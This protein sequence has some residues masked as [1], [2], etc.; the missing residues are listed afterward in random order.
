[1]R[2]GVLAFDESD[3]R[4]IIATVDDE[5]IPLDRQL[6]GS[7]LALHRNERHRKV[8][9]CFGIERLESH[10]QASQA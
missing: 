5:S 8:W 2:A 3:L 10:Q 1:M 9:Q 7:A 4:E 6:H